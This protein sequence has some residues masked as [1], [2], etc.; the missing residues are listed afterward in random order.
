MAFRKEVE[1]RGLPHRLHEDPEWQTV[2]D[3][4]NWLVTL[5][6]RPGAKPLNFYTA[7]RY[8]AALLLGFQKDA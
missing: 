6:N 3:V 1:D 2:T 8:A 4:A 7:R 5:C